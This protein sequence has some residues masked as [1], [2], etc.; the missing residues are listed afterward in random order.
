MEI[1]LGT[2][3]ND[4]HQFFDVMNRIARQTRR[5][6][7]VTQDIDTVEQIRVS[8]GEVF[9]QLVQFLGLSAAL[10]KLNRDIRFGRSRD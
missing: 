10:N 6:K 4:R 7:V 3:F 2:Y 1:L 9:D 8:L 5:S